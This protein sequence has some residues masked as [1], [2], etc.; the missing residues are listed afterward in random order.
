MAQHRRRKKPRQAS[1]RTC[2]ILHSKRRGMERVEGFDGERTLAEFGRQI[3]Q[4][5]SRKLMDQSNRVTVHACKWEGREYPVVWDRQRHAVV[6][7]LPVDALAG[8]ESPE[9]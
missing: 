7:V 1:K 3:R 6:T 4:S 9:G 2:Q 5:R 8:F